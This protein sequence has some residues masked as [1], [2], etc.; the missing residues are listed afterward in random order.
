MGQLC[1]QSLIAPLEPE[2]LGGVECA[3]PSTCQGT[4][5]TVRARSGGQLPGPQSCHLVVRRLVRQASFTQRS[6]HRLR[7]TLGVCLEL[8]LS[9][10]VQLLGVWQDRLVCSGEKSPLTHTE[11]GLLAGCLLLPAAA[12]VPGPRAG[13]HPLHPPPVLVGQA[14]GPRV[15]SRSQKQLAGLHPGRC[16]GVY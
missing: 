3:L 12:S 6:A 11:A 7:V 13:R 14:G 8:V 5:S 1:L 15:P 16:A 10:S 9:T 4:H 2:G